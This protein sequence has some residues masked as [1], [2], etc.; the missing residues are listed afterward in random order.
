[1]KGMF[2]SIRKKILRSTKDQITSVGRSQE[3]HFA[4]EKIDPK[5]QTSFLYGIYCFIL[6]R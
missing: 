3:F 5:N 2:D 4:T 6:G 1:M